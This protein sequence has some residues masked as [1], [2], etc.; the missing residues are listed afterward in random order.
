MAPGYLHDETIRNL[1]RCDLPIN[2]YKLS[3]SRLE[4]NGELGQLQ[5]EVNFV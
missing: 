5:I 3:W 2:H 4:V 1:L